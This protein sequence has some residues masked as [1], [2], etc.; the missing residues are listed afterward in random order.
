M[1]WFFWRALL[2]DEGWQQDQ[3]SH[4]P[5]ST[6]S[7]FATLRRPGKRSPWQT[8][9]FGPSSFSGCLVSHPNR[10]SPSFANSG[11]PEERKALWMACL[12]V[13]QWAVNP[14]NFQ[15]LRNSARKHE[16][17]LKG[18][19]VNLDSEVWSQRICRVHNPEFQFDW[20]NV[21]ALNVVTVVFVLIMWKLEIFSASLA[22]H[23]IG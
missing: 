3:P 8:V 13:K 10:G 7:P 17:K 21:L 16:T 2:Q 1:I 5:P 15:R 23:H 22:I 18:R 11:M 19:S 20:I 4:A 9:S 12:S 6:D 14:E